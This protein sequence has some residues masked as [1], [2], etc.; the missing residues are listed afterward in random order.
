MDRTS[1]ISPPLNIT[2]SVEFQRLAAHVGHE[3]E[4]VTYGTLNVAIE[5]LDCGEVIVDEDRYPES[6]DESLCPAESQE[7]RT[8]H[9]GLCVLRVNHE[10]QHRFP[11]WTRP[12]EHITEDEPNDVSDAEFHAQHDASKRDGWV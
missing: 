2:D 1:T 5:C 3:V 12:G 10:G 7:N 9:T 4:V 6:T 8:D 11:V